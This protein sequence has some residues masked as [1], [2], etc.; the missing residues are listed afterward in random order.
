LPVYMERYGEHHIHS[1]RVRNWLGKTEF[2]L[3][4][5]GAT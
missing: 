1:A 4:D 5:V 2:E 3:E